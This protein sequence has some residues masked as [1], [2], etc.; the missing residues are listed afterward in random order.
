[1]NNVSAKNKPKWYKAG[2]WGDLE[3][4]DLLPGCPILTPPDDFASL[5]RAAKPGDSIQI[6]AHIDYANLII[7]SQT[8]DLQHD[9]KIEQVGAPQRITIVFDHARR[10]AQA[11]A[12]IGNS[13]GK[14]SNADGNM[15]DLSQK[16][17]NEMQM[18]KKQ[19]DEK[20]TEIGKYKDK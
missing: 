5:L 14:I 19:L 3:Q 1:M 12:V 7:A 18:N 9:G 2:Q 10:I 6:S 11:L 16:L 15:K 4:G 13:G 17:E 20:N 8:C